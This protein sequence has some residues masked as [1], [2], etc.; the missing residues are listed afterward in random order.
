M[1][2]NSTTDNYFDLGQI[3]YKNYTLLCQGKKQTEKLTIDAVVSIDGKQKS[4]TVSDFVRTTYA[5][6]YRA[7]DNRGRDLEESKV[8]V[9]TSRS[10]V[11]EA[12]MYLMG[13]KVP[14]TAIVDYLDKANHIK[15]DK[16]AYLERTAI[17]LSLKKKSARKRY[18][19]SEKDMKIS[20]DSIE[21]LEGEA[22]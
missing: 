3:E 17:I 7:I 13:H 9:G 12:F 19:P 10:D 21:I 5:L 15:Y 4:V 14:Y 18:L 2:T 20:F 22:K 6:Y 16:I 11:K 8:V 1:I